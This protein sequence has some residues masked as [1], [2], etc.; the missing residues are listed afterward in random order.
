[1]YNLQFDTM[2]E[3]SAADLLGLHNYCNVV[4]GPRDYTKRVK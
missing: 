3:R 1:M 4:L 2:S